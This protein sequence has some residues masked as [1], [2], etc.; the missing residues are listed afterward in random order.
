MTQNPPNLPVIR[1]I[2]SEQTLQQVPQ[3]PMLSGT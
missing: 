1:G 2:Q 3:G